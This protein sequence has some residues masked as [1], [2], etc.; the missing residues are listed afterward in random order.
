MCVHVWWVGGWVGEGGACVSGWRRERARASHH[1]Y[2]YKPV[3]VRV[4]VS[5]SVFLWVG[6]W[7]VGGR[8]GE[9]SMTS[10]DISLISTG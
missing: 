1:K 5:V 7:F 6:G 3:C 4:S 9:H 10:T 8:E 2:K